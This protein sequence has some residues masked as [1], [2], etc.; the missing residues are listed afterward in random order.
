MALAGDHAQVLVGG[1][2][3]TGDIQRVTVEDQ[4]TLYDVTSFSDEVHNFVTGPRR[5]GM[6]HSGYMNSAAA[7][8]H[9]V[10]SGLAVENSVVSLLLGSN[11][12]PAVGDVVFTLNG[13]QGSYDTMPE[14]GKFIPFTAR[15]ANAA[16]QGGWGR[17]LA[18]PVTITNTTNGVALDNGAATSA[19]GAATLHVLL[20]AATDRYSIIVEGA[21][22][23]GFTVG[24]VTLATFTLNASMVGSERISISGAIPRYVRYRAT[25]TVGSANN[26]VR[27]AVGLVRF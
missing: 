7:R 21:T 17:M 26:P 23:A 1:F 5:M 13:L 11:A 27:L 16:A 14:T 24:L 6:T 9:P 18:V 10:L 3:L 12:P 22:D 4:R 8:S 20:A 15:F 2:E 25:R 19:G